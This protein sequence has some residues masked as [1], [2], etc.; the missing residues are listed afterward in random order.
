MATVVRGNTPE[1]TANSGR[2]HSHRLSCRSYDCE[3]KLWPA[4]LSGWRTSCY[5][6]MG[7]MLT[8]HP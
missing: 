5:L 3:L 8:M 7:I 1:L 6:L 4:D 2:S